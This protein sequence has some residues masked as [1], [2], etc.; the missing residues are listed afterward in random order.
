MRGDL[1]ALATNGIFN[2]AI[3][4][5]SGLGGDLTGRYLHEQ[6]SVYF[7][8][9]VDQKNYFG[10]S[11]ITGHGYGAYD[12]EHRKTAA[13][14]LIENYNAPYLLRPVQGRWT[15]RMQ[16]KMIAEDLPHPDNRVRLDEEGDVVIDWH[17]HSDYAHRGIDRAEAMLQDL[18]PFKIENI[19]TK[20]PVETEAHI[21][22][23]HRM[24][25]DPARSVTDDLMRVHGTPGLHALGSGAFPSCS[26]ANPTLTLSALALRAGQGVS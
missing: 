4:L 6:Y 8:L 19:V 1:I 16:I 20:Q 10:G 13:A 18:M 23:T 25:S 3:L 5:R 24:G 15:E 2:A 26:P 17:G 12:G 7:G 14:V 9:D 11:T 22:G 21:Q